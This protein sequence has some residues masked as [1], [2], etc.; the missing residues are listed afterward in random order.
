[1]I[2]EFDCLVIQRESFELIVKEEVN[3]LFIQFE[4]E[5]LQEGHVIV[6]IL[7]IIGEIEVERDQLIKESIAKQVIYIGLLD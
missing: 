1:M 3:S 5:T 7:I 6:H 2:V 4:R